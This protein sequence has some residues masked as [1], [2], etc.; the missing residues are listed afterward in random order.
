M[1]FIKG[2]RAILQRDAIIHRYLGNNMWFQRT[3]VD[4]K[5]IVTI[6]KRD[7]YPLSQI[8]KDCVIIQFDEGDD[9]DVYFALPKYLTEVKRFPMRTSPLKFIDI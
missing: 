3:S 7:I 8:K 5:K 6:I 4:T 2:H 1:D 9:N